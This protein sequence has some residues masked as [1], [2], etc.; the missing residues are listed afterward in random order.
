MSAKPAASGN[1]KAIIAKRVENMEAAAAAAPAPAAP[2]PV[3]ALAKAVKPLAPV[4]PIVP[5]AKSLA[6]SAPNQFGPV[7]T[8]GFTFTH[9][10]LDNTLYNTYG[11]NSL[12]SYLITK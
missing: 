1:M 3:P 12:L 10:E 2:A 8:H 11:I 7:K 9:Q 6:V 4:K 5:L